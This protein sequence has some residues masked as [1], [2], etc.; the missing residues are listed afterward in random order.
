MSM[1]S[2]PLPQVPA[3]TARVAKAAFPKG[4]LAMRIRDVLGEVYADTRFASA[5]A[6][7][8]RV[9]VSPGQLMMVM[10]LQYTENLTDRQAADAARDR[11]SWK[12][13][14]GLALD[15]PG[16][17]A[18][19]LC[20][21]RTRLVAHDATGLALDLLLEKLTGAGLVKPGGRARTDSTH[22]LARIRGLNRLELAGETIRAAL[23]ALAVAAPGWLV[24]EI[25]HGWQDRYA[26]R[27]DSFR[28]PDSD[29]K[30]SAL[31]LQYGRDGYALLEAVYATDTPQW[32]GGLPAVDALRRIWIQQYHR[33]TADGREVIARREAD[34]HGLPPGRFQLTSPYDLDARYSVKRGHGWTGYKVHF[35]EGCDGGRDETDR[36]LP[37]LI[38]NVA[39]TDAVVPDAAMT[40]PIHEQLQAKDLL[41]ARHLLDSGYPSATLLVGIRRDFGVQLVTPLLADQSTQA[42]AGAGYDRT[43]FAIDFDAQQATCP[44]GQVSSTWHDSIQNGRPAIVVTFAAK[45]C[46]PCPVRADCTK[47]ATGR[48]QLTLQPREIHEAQTAA[49][50]EQT[51]QA[52]K[53]EYKTR[54]GVEGTMHQAVAATGIRRSRYLGI[55]KIRLEHHLAAAAIN[56]IRLDAYFTGRPLDRGH[57]SHLAR[58]DFTLAA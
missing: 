30:R 16:F 47:A 57:T 17:D 27:V 3:L 29:T 36:D 28:L 13:A 12:Y 9:G 50:A 52:W 58:L 7:S 53:T 48:R 6:V 44:H 38:V 5:F 2:L 18:S 21:F 4:N 33:Y 42:K 22:V 32:L 8:G 40:Q 20:E 49:R 55:D 25:D 10:V 46:R 26:Q 23:E 35:T 39:T 54:A 24:G 45:T 43:A 19:V 56:L 41:P 15:D 31:A 11:M 14:L 34:V 51:T 1:E 37:N